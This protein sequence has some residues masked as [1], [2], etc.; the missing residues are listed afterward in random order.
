MAN[1]T[2]DTTADRVRNDLRN[3]AHRTS[4]STAEVM[5]EYVLEPFLYRR[6]AS[7]LGQE[8]FVHKGG[9]LPTQF[10]ARRMTRDIDIL[11]HHHRPRRAPPDLLPRL[12]PPTKHRLG[13]I[14]QRALV[15]PRSAGTCPHPSDQARQRTRAG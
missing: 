10:G 12:A 6:A 4:L 14:S 8:H 11:G 5:V 7:P 1:P 9:L 2:R 15:P 13:D 3:L